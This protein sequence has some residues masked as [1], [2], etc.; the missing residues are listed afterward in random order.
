MANHIDDS[1]G[2]ESSLFYDQIYLAQCRNIES[3]SFCG[4]LFLTDF[5][6][7]D[8]G[9]KEEEH[10]RHSFLFFNFSIKP[11]RIIIEKDKDGKL[12]ISFICAVKNVSICE[13]VW[14]PSEYKLS[15]DGR[16]ISIKKIEGVLS[17]IQDGRIIS[18]KKI[19]GVL[20]VI[21]DDHPQTDQPPPTTC[22]F[23]DKSHDDESAIKAVE[24]NNYIDRLHEISR[25][26]HIDLQLLIE[27]MTVDRRQDFPH[28]SPPI[29]E[30]IES[31]RVPASNG[32][33]S[34]FQRNHY[35]VVS[36]NICSGYSNSLSITVAIPSDFLNQIIASCHVVGTN[37]LRTVSKY[38]QQ[39]GGLLEL[40]YDP[41]KIISR[42]IQQLLSKQ[43]KSTDH[44]I[45]LSEDWVLVNYNASRA[46]EVVQIDKSAQGVSEVLPIDWSA[47]SASRDLE[48]VSIDRSALRA[49]ED[50]S[51]D[52]SRSSDWF[53]LRELNEVSKNLFASSAREVV[54]SNCLEPDDSADITVPKEVKPFQDFS[55]CGPKNG[56]I[57]VWNFSGRVHQFWVSEDNQNLFYNRL[58]NLDS[59]YNPEL[60]VLFNLSIIHSL[61]VYE[62]P[63]TGLYII[64]I[65]SGGQIYLSGF[66]SESAIAIFAT[67]QITS[68]SNQDVFISIEYISESIFKCVFSDGTE[69][70]FSI[71][72]LTSY[73]GSYCVLN[74]VLYA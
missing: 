3:K 69:K 73:W 48:V 24:I 34:V 51:I 7:G 38:L 59:L 26:Y 61:E 42:L 64:V 55:Q 19:E 35:I 63:S 12:K 56:L 31:D 71:E 10:L 29:T 20:S 16:I 33:L 36:M 70:T 6:R 44:Q 18:I 32:L 28:Y 17:D 62:I 25:T 9:K 30:V 57:R 21:Q 37:V 13:H 54:S 66:S 40:G 65:H 45:D 58:S 27:T 53:E 60:K 67:F 2:K 23:S 39:L 22:D 50:V 14:N 4:R 1:M 41:S 5:D 52:R 8:D 11:N 47:W 68:Y 46:L 49:L 15:K 74:Q 72:L 43:R